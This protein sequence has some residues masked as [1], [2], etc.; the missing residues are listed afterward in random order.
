MD[1]SY[2]SD[3]TLVSA[4][5]VANTR[6]AAIVKLPETADIRLFSDGKIY[7]SKAFAL[8][9]DLEFQ[10]KKV[11]VPGSDAEVIGNGLDIFSSIN[12]SMLEAPLKEPV[13]FAYVIPKAFA[14]VN[15]WANTKYAE[16]GTPAASVFTQGANVF[17]KKELL[18]IVTETLG[19]DWNLVDYVDFEMKTDIV[20]PSATGMYDIQKV[21]NTKDGPII[22]NCRRQNISISPLVIVHTEL[23]K[24]PTGTS[25][26]TPKLAPVET[27]PQGAPF[28][29]SVPKPT[30]PPVVGIPDSAIP[31][32]PLFNA[33]A[34][35]P[36]VTQ[37]VV[38]EIVPPSSAADAAPDWAKGLGSL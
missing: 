25:T 2:L 35:T 26:D 3:I 19:V 21:S 1:L 27:K 4:P 29:E 23:K 24:V 31:A 9:A 13:L 34:P 20:I 16:D 5:K 36:A 22:K 11:L 18:K 7:P 10:P 38:P 28:D 6:T 32:N 37:E 15:L 12:W 8:K 14:K 33:P 17:S 30:A